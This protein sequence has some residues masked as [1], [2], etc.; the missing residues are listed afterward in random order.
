NGVLVLPQIVIRPPQLD[1]DY[2]TP[3][4]TLG[5]VNAKTGPGFDN[6]V[7]LKGYNYNNDGGGNWMGIDYVKLNYV[8]LQ[9]LPPNISGGKIN[10][11]WT[12]TGALESAPTV[13]GPWTPVV[14]APASPPYSEDV[15]AGQNRF[16]RLK[17]Q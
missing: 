16:Y 9:F 11:D 5:S 8:Q 4:F 17:K 6:I 14:P 7:S 13:K 15:V 10:L 12:G 3:E 1:I 2:S